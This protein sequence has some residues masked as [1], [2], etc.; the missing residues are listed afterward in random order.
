MKDVRKTTEFTTE[1]MK[2]TEDRQGHR[3]TDVL[4][5]HFLELPKLFEKEIPI[6]END[7]I[8]QRMLVPVHGCR[9]TVSGFFQR[10]YVNL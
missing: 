2:N 4:K 3:L 6:E 9:F 10:T 8:A 5:V 7:V 1:I